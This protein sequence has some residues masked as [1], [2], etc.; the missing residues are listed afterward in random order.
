[1]PPQFSEILNAPTRWRI[2][3][4]QMA[5]SLKALQLVHRTLIAAA[6]AIIALLV[7]RD[8]GPGFYAAAYEEFRIL[9]RTIPEV[10]ES[11]ATEIKKFYEAS[12]FIRIVADVAQQLK[13]SAAKITVD[14]IGDSYGPPSLAPGAEHTIDDFRNYI[15]TARRFDTTTVYR[16]TS[17]LRALFTRTLSANRVAAG[18]TEFSFRAR[19]SIVG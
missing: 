3:I 15:A 1:M 12:G 10:R 17:R 2:I 13:V 9:Q 19:R 7:A 5:E 14:V 16:L 18:S 8:D 4:L 6:V 11:R